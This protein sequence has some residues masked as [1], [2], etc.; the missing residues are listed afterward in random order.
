MTSAPQSPLRGFLSIS[1]PSVLACGLNGGVPSGEGSHLLQQF[2]EALGARA[3][4]FRDHKLITSALILTRDHLCSRG[5]SLS[6]R[7][8]A[9]LRADSLRSAAVRPVLGRLP[10]SVQ[11]DSDM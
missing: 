4:A 7:V 10:N 5:S 11:C 1:L 6:F 3:D 2:A 8:A 9:A